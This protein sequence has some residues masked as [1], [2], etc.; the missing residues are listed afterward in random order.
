[1]PAQEYLRRVV[2][3]ELDEVLS[4]LPAI[5][6]EGA[7]GVGK[8][9]T[10]S[11][12]SMTTYELDSPATQELAKADVGL[13]LEG[14]R[15]ILIDEWHRYPPVWDAVRRAVD[16]GAAGGSF[17]LTGSAI[18]KTPPTHSGAGRIVAIRMRPLSLFERQVATPTVSLAALL[19]GGNEAVTGRCDC[20]GRTYL[21][22]I[23][24]SG[25]PGIRKYQGRARRLQLDGYT[26]R[27]VDRDLKEEAGQV[28][29]KPE[30][31]RRWMRAYAAAISTTA[32]Y[33]TIR[34]AAT[35]RGQQTVSKEAA[36]GYRDA[37][38]RLWILEPVPAWAPT[39]NHINELAQPEK[40][41]LVDPALA[42]ALLGMDLRARLRGEP[43]ERAIPRDGAYAG[44]LF[45]SLVTQSVRIYAQQAEAEVRHLR[46]HRG[47]HEIDLIVERRDGHVIAMEVKFASAIDDRDVRNLLWLKDK[48][49][50]DLVNAVVINT[51]PAAYRRQDGVAVVPAAL[52]GP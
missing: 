47:E 16:A 37:L 40:H 19:G 42:T 36:I 8:T 15:P 39:L 13:L 44:A 17:L 9:R 45:E 25:F 12:R 4:Q 18:P 29:R 14:A 26:T 23:L 11:L 48:I 50:S 30:A 1:M 35:G 7:K 27:V 21:E 43:P 33:E 5:A 34:D 49:G 32:T 46:T 2:D 38:L 3:G 6:F 28:V 41:Q 51:G 52:L 20:T 22:E 10:A 24:A 31:L